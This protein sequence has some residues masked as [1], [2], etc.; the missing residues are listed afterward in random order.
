MAMSAIMN[1]I[2]WKFAI[3][4]PNAL[5][6]SILEAFV[7]R[8]LRDSDRDRANLRPAMVEGRHRYSK[9]SPSRPTSALAGTRTSS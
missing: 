8:A 3:G 7:E 6:C 4:C 9:P 2:A 5:R 1:S